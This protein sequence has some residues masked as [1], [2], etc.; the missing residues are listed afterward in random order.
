MNNI[1]NRTEM[2]IGK[3]GLAKLKNCHIIIVGI[4]GVGSYV[5]EALARS[6]I[7]QLT[8]IDN[9][10][11]A[12]SNINRQLH[13]TTKTIGKAKVDVMKA[14]LQAINP[15]LVVNAI[16]ALY[17]ADSA[18]QL[19]EM[20]C[21]YVVDAI[22]M[23]S[24]KLHLIDYCQKNQLAIIS[25]MGTANK[26]D[27]TKI[28]LGDIYQTTTDPLA[29]IMRRELRKLG[30]AALKVV[31]SSEAPIKTNSNEQNK[32]RPTVGS[33]AFVPSVAGLIIAAEVVK[34]LL[35]TDNNS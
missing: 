31:Y 12:E 22:D 13:A 6:G 18:A 9:D 30:I 3:A 27:P 7:G 4:G 34:D 21:D 26:L 17:N 28:T 25:S 16:Q 5:A 14:R 20:S 35:A 1:F 15:N 11:I 23:V 10:V 19:I 2:L 8:L 24:A 29:R 32:R 33:V